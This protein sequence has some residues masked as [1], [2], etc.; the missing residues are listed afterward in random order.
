[1]LIALE[2][3]LPETASERPPRRPGT[4]FQPPSTGAPM[5]PQLNRT[6]VALCRASTEAGKVR[7]QFTNGRVKPVKPRHDG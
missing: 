2:E 7:S 4:R 5:E 3:P 1:M 6:A